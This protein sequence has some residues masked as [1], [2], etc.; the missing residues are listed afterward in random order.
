MTAT[1]KSS[2]ANQLQST[3]IDI[4]LKSGMRKHTT[5]HNQTNSKKLNNHL[6][7]KPKAARDHEKQMDIKPFKISI[8]PE[9][10]EKIYFD[11]KM[12]SLILKVTSPTAKQIMKIVPL[13]QQLTRSRTSSRHISSNVL[14]DRA[15][16][17]QSSEPIKSQLLPWRRSA[18]NHDCRCSVEIS[19][20]QET[21][22]PAILDDVNL[23][24][25][26]TWALALE[27]I[28][29]SLRLA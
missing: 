15:A 28:A 27:V 6:R 20:F 9:T 18:W 21:S 22:C 13:A 5:K 3:T 26:W 4:D 24:P 2:T 10:S 17:T 19:C 12:F 29:V 11:E 14:V 1:R 7:Q 25:A 16:P 23:L 8:S